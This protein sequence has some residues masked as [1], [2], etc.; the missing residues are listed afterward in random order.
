M[1][2]CIEISPKVLALEVRQQNCAVHKIFMVYWM[3]VMVPL[4]F[5]NS[6]IFGFGY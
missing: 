2:K 5:Q 1:E 4:M 6:N 3:F